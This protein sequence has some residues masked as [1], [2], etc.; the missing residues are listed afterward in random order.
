[1]AGSSSAF[2]VA[3]INEEPDPMISHQLL[4]DEGILIVSPQAPLEASDFEEVAREVDPYIEEKGSLRGVLV[5]A[6]SF[7]GWHNFGAL[8]SHL[9]FVRDHHAKIK[10]IAAVTDS[11]FLTIVPRIA[12]HFVN[13]EVKHFSSGDKEAALDWIRSSPDQHGE[14][15][16]AGTKNTS[17]G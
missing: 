14:P 7:P 11:K 8:I 9:R 15:P 3:P 5:E 10:R 6:E 12:Q 13:A 16:G 4:R 1:M 17:K 2:P